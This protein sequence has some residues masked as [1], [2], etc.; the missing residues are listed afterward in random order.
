MTKCKHYTTHT[1]HDKIEHL[2][3]TVEWEMLE[4]STSYW[5]DID[6]HRYK[7]GLCGEVKYYSSAARAYYEDGVKCSIPG[8]DK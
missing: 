8:L 5:E 3:G 6:L 1:V 7:C 2:D 4:Q